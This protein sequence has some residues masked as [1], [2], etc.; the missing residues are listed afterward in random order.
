MSGLLRLPSLS[1]L[2]FFA[3]AVSLLVFKAI[4]DRRRRKGLPY[5][6]GPRPLPLIG[7]LLNM[8][9]S[10]GSWKAYAKLG[11]QYGDIISLRVLGQTIVVLNSHQRAFDLLE[12]RSALYSDRVVMPFYDLQISQS[13]LDDDAWRA[14]RRSLDRSLRPNAITQYRPMQSVKGHVLLKG[15]LQKPEDYTAHLEQL[16]GSLILSLTYGYEVKGHSDEHLTRALALNKITNATAL[17]GANV[18]NVFPFLRYFPGWLPGMSF[19]ALARQGREAGDASM[20]RP[21]DSFKEAVDKGTA[22]NSIALDEM[23]EYQQFKSDEEER[24]VMAALGSLFVAGSDTTTSLLQSFFLM[25]AT[26]PSVQKRAQAELD[27]VLAGKRLPN[28]DDRPKLPYINAICKELG[29]WRMVT[30]IGLPHA[31]TEDDV[32]DGY[33]IPKGKRLNIRAML[34]DPAPYP[35]PE[36]FKPER[37]LTEDGH[38][39]DD[40]LINVAF[41]MGKRI[42]PG[43]FIVDSTVFI[44]VSMV[45]ST[46]T[47]GRPRNPP[48]NET[49]LDQNVNIGFVVTRPESFQCTI[50]PRSKDA[51]E[52]ILAAVTSNVNDVL[53]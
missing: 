53:P 51:E 2:D 39:K 41:G 43:R 16:Q 19:K 46:F 9:A 22:R 29:R 25:L 6:P 48:P 32:Y 15:L 44:V 11:E 50:V 49:P 34:H 7:N 42:C 17:P 1:V 38:F 18:V 37:F 24:N 52:L 40:P 30:P 20:T 13:L 35:E 12:R 8:P 3:V 21:W 5:P 33:F 23:R 26:Y 31:S 14:G 27:T 10:E 4:L 45:L 36:V 28:F 47:V